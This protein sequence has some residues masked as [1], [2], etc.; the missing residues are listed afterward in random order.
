L[1][2]DCYTPKGT[3]S[4]TK[5]K[6]DD[7]IF[8]VQPNDSLV[9]QIFVSQRANLRSGNAATKNR[10]MVVGS[11]RKI[12]RQKGLGLAR[13][14]SIKSPLQV[15]GGVTFG[16][17]P[18]NFGKKIPKQMNRQAIKSMLSDKLLAK[19]LVILDFNG[20][21]AKPS[22]KDFVTM[23]SKLNIDSSCLILTHGLN[24]EFF[25]SSRNVPKVSVMSAERVSVYDLLQNEWVV[26]LKNS[27]DLL[28]SRLNTNIIRRKEIQG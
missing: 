21:Y 4:K 20:E 9:H 27:V 28:E 13:K 12:R 2:I 23:L 17:S 19:K 7:N 22:T 3:I 26:L 16:P 14:G 11:T 10:S 1:N 6:L 8:G 18:R 15:G 5:V 25:L 24:R